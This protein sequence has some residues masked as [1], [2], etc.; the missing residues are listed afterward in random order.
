MTIII[1]NAIEK[2]LEFNNSA[3]SIKGALATAGAPFL[4]IV[5]DT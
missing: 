3:I 5:I 4:V 2:L 1:R